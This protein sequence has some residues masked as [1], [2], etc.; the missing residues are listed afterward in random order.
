MANHYYSDDGKYFAQCV[1][2]LLRRQPEMSMSNDATDAEF[3]GI[4]YGAETNGCSVACVPDL[5]NERGTLNINA[6]KSS[7]H[8]AGLIAQ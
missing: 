2:G 6:R 3:E 7:P 1:N 4:H 5:T 8:P